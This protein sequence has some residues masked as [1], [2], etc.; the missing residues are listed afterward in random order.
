MNTELND[1]LHYID[2]N[3][4]W[5]FTLDYFGDKSHSNFIKKIQSIL[6]LILIGLLGFLLLIILLTI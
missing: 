6:L 2:T 3:D 4:K 5:K 1:V